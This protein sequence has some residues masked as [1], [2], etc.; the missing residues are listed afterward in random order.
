MTP[1]TLLTGFLGSGKTSLLS[2]LLN[3][4]LFCNAAVIINE[5]GAISLDHDLVRAADETIVTLSNG[6]LCCRVSS[7]IA[8]T[9]AELNRKRAEGEIAFDR[10]VIETSGLADPVPLLH[11]LGAD[12]IIAMDFVLAGVVTTIDATTGTATLARFDEARR[13]V[14]LADLVLLTKLDLSEAD[15]AATT[16]SISSINTTAAFL[17]A[18]DWDGGVP[19]GPSAGDR[20]RPVPLRLGTRHSHR[21]TTIT[22]ERD[23][24]VPAV[25]VPLF[26]EGL[27]THLGPRL[28][29][30]KGLV[31]LV[32]AP[33]QP[34]VVHAV[35]H[36]VHQP[37]FLPAWPSDNRR[38]R[39]VLIGYDIPAD[40]PALL[41]NAIEAEVG[42]VAADASP[43]EMAPRQRSGVA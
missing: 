1:I 14:A 36:M 3:G 8:A 43:H 42:D 15:A 17:D 33:E 2:R 29:R 38:T 25:A 5:F 31:A 19:S 23:R 35:Q 11:A 4:P 27:A 34:M 12:T 41:L 28:L 26:L 37:N 21:F 16:G 9:L 20:L 6:C 7:D 39:I 24:P 40:W 32:E 10:V 30:L 13:Q 18:R 22:I